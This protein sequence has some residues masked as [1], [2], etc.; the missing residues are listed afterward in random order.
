VRREPLLN[1]RAP[2]PGSRQQRGCARAEPWLP[3]LVCAPLGAH[4]RG[5]GRQPLSGAPA[6]ALPTEQ[7]MQTTF[8]AF[9][10]LLLLLATAAV[11]AE[12][13]PL[14]D[15]AVQKTLHAMADASTWYHPDQFGEFAGMRHYAHKQYDS[16]LKYFE[17]GAYYADKLSQLSIGLMHLNGEGV[18]KDP[19]TAYA[20]FC[21][22][23]E[24]D[25]PDFVA[26][27]D[28]TKAALTPAQL[29]QAAPIREKLEA[30]Y[31]DN[32]AKPRMAKQLH[33][34]QMQMT[35]SRTGFDSGVAQIRN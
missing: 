34:G 29:E 9:A 21:V 24:R 28:R 30:R 19:V 35:G 23:A 2:L 22:A 32:V 31:G 26:T 4:H 12:D 20:W 13:D 15:P 10:I 8:R 25:Y 7:D 27:R 5:A 6:V 14:D 33:L 17:V 16:A 3:A 18:P 11:H 1:R